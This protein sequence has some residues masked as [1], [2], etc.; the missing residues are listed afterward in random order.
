MNMMEHLATKEPTGVTYVVLSNGHISHFGERLQ[1]AFVCVCLYVLGGIHQGPSYLAE[2]T[3]KIH[4][5]ATCSHA[6]VCVC[7]CILVISSVFPGPRT[8]AGLFN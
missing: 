3:D 1:R 6:C 5:S 8:L 7:V 2:L 4:L